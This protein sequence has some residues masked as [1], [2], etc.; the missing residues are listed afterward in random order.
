MIP[1]RPGYCHNAYCDEPSTL[2]VRV[3]KIN[4]SWTTGVDYC[5]QHAHETAQKMRENFKVVV[6]PHG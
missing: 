3:R 5:E 4:R 1:P 2:V 6:E